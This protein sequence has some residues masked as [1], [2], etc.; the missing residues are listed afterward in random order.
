MSL[1]AQVGNTMNAFIFVM[2]PLLFAS[3]VSAQ[4]VYTEKQVIAYAKSIDAKTL[5][6]SL[7]SQGLENWLRSAVP[8]AQRMIWLVEN[9]CWQKPDRG[10]DYPLCAHIRVIS[11][12][13][14]AEF[15]VQ[16]GTWHKGIV[17]SPKLSEFGI[18][19]HQDPAWSTTGSTDKLSELPGMLS[20]PNRLIA[21]GARKLYEEVVSHHPVGIPTSEQ[22]A[23][24][25]PFL[26][27]RLTEQLQTAQACEEDYFN[28]R[29]TEDSAVKPVW[30]ESGIFSGG[31]EEA[32][33]TNSFAYTTAP[34]NDGIFTVSVDLTYHPDPM[35]PVSRF[36]TAKAK[37]VTENGR[38]VVD[39]IRIFDSDSPDPRASSAGPSHQ[40]SESFVGC[41]GPRWVGIPV[42]DK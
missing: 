37:V 42:S 12:G 2:L 7:P 4:H 15:L 5:D 11:N 8:H 38:F 9:T 27:K 29:R 13:Q 14:W 20:Q 28:H 25:R 35:D 23:T 34:Q 32:V 33:P 22:M 16:I 40:L 3:S 1:L 6:P 21:D 19:I 18:S 36:W 17:G 31:G 26:S 41:N 24:I 30:L 10:E 39:D